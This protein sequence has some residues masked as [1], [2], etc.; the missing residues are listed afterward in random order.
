M[1]SFRWKGCLAGARSVFSEGGRV[2]AGLVRSHRRTEEGPERLVHF[3][4][5]AIQHQRQSR[6]RT[7]YRRVGTML[8]NQLHIIHHQSAA[9]NSTDP[10]CPVLSCPALPPRKHAQKTLIGY[11]GPNTKRQ[12]V[13]RNRKEIHCAI[14][15]GIMS[16][17]TA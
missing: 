16:F 12:S 3:L 5:Q 2:P 1:D 14:H 8:L 17:I 7:E 4:Q 6:G 10:K 15:E 9:Q 11:V 13:S